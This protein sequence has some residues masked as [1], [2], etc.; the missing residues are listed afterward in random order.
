MSSQRK[1]RKDS[2]AN[3]EIPQNVTIMDGG[4]R[5][6]IPWEDYIKT[7]EGKTHHLNRIQEE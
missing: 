6:V 4:A 2:L 3:Q 5:K 7:E 1:K